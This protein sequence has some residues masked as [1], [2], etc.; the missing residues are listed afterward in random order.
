MPPEFSYHKKGKLRTD[1]KFYIWYDPLLFIRGSNL[2]IRRCVPEIEQGKVLDKCHASPYGGQ[3]AGDR[4]THK[5]LQSC[6]YWPTL[7]RDYFEWVK[8]CDK[9]QR[10]DNIRRM[11]ETPL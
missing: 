9:C 11:N 1:S 4:I 6:F 8:H 2:I 3:F 5:I 7:F 10:M